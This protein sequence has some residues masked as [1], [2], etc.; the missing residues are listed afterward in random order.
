MA[1]GRGN[2]EFDEVRIGTGEPATRDHQAFVTLKLNLHHGD[3]VLSDSEQW[4]D[5]R[6]RHTIAGVRYG[7]VGMRVGGVRRI[8]IGS[9][10]AYGAEG[11]PGLIPPDA[12]LIC[13]VELL[14][15]KP[16]H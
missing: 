1:R 4:I 16:T 2:V 6:R 10:L 15:L 3:C 8:T 5:L 12:L 9:H 11:L 7:V 13:D 14:L